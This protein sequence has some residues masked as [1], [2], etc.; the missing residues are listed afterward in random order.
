MWKMASHL[1]HVGLVLRDSEYYHD[2]HSAICS[3]P[4]VLGSL[5]SPEKRPNSQTAK[6][7]NL[8]FRADFKLQ[9]SALEIRW[10]LVQLLP[11]LWLAVAH[12]N[13]DVPTV[14]GTQFQKWLG[15]YVRLHSIPRGLPTSQ[16]GLFRPRKVS[17]FIRKGSLFSPR[18]TFPLGAKRAKN[19]EFRGE[20]HQVG[21]K[22]EP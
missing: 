11:L 21:S 18:R 8:K 9:K 2:Y 22:E 15:R 7:A 20:D 17:S 19:D 1:D 12:F 6:S 16:E 14:P 3:H 13:N 4:S 5:D 10:K